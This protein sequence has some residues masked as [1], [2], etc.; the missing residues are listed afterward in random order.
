MMQYVGGSDRTVPFESAPSA[1]TRALELI[2]KRIHQTLLVKKEF[3][4]V[5]SAAYMERQRMAVG[6]GY[7]L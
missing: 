6:I 5:L 7:L 4:E 3:N 2:Q 1:V